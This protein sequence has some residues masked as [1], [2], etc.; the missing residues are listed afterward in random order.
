MKKEMHKSKTFWGILLAL[1]SYYLGTDWLTP[2][3]GGL[4]VYGFRDA[5]K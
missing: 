1:L 2:V 4:T 5:L 3:F